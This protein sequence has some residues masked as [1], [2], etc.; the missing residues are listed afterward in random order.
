VD[1]GVL[2]KSEADK[3]IKTFKEHF[4]IK[5]M[6]IDACER[7]LKKLAGVSDPEK[8]RKIIGNEFIAVFEEEATK[9]KGVDFLAQGTLYPD[10]IESVSFKGPSA[11]IKSHHNVGGLP[12]VMKLKLIE[13]LRELFKDEVRAVGEE[14]GLS[15]EICWRH[16]FP[17]PGL[18]I[19][20]LGEVTSERL[21]ILRE[22]DA[23]VL[24]E[25]KRAGLY[26]ELW[27]AFAVLLPVQ[28]VG[29]MGDERTYENAVAVRAV[30]SQ[31]A[32]KQA[33]KRSQGRQPGGL[34]HK[35]QTSRHNRVG[36]RGHGTF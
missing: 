35:L 20:C 23:I 14:L 15:E 19:R 11:V 36:I 31:D 6:H 34:R 5:L 8:K 7:F 22:A 27:Q 32:I 33:H 10:V 9:I 21:D 2:R 17:G 29:V 30:T 24:E 4:H 13:P 16:P 3:V 18:A 1:N 28:T 25:I 26:R 12:E